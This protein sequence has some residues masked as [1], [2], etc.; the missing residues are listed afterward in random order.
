MTY[1]TRADNVYLIDTKMFGFDR[2][3]SAY[4]VVGDEVALI[5]TGAPTSWEAVREAIVAHGFALEDIGHIFVTHAEHPDH[6][7]NVGVLLRENDRAVVYVN[8]TGIEYLTDPAIESENRRRNLSPVMA[9][10][11]GEMEPVSPSRIRLLGDGDV[12]DLGN[13]VKLKVMFTPGHQPS[14]LVLLEE[15]HSGL[16][17]NDLSGAYFA[18]ADASWIFSPYRADVRQAMASLKKIESLPMKRLFLGHFGIAERPQDVLARALV[19]MQALLDIGAE[20]TREGRPDEIERRVLATLMP[21]V[22]KMGKVRDKKLYDYLKGELT[23]S[24][25]RAFAR[26]YQRSA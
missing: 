18:D 16:F 22:E 12:V 15:K 20:C 14:G 24:L 3:N 5:D 21:E 25:A 26:Y 8:P 9:A 1:A 7:G 10:R 11:F 23:P 17:I 2:F 4:I 6:S 19:K 13:E